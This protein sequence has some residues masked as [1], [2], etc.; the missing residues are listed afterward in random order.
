VKRSAGYSRLHGRL[1]LNAFLTAPTDVQEAFS[2]E[3]A[4]VAGLQ[5]PVIRFVAF[6]ANQLPSVANLLWSNRT[7]LSCP[8]LL[9]PLGG[10]DA[11]KDLVS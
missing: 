6:L 8:V 4:I 3:V 10:C 5:I 9:K 2:A 7:K 1:A 11:G